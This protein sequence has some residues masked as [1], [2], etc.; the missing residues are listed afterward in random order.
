MLKDLAPSFGT[1]PELG[2]CFFNFSIWQEKLVFLIEEIEKV[3]GTSFAAWDLRIDSRWFDVGTDSVLRKRRNR[4][5]GNKKHVWPLKELDLLESSLKFSWIN[6]RALTREIQWRLLSN[7]WLVFYVRWCSE[8]PWK[9][10]WPWA[11][12]AIVFLQS[13]LELHPNPWLEQMR[14]FE[15]FIF[16][17][18][19]FKPWMLS[20]CFN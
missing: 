3:S 10:Q 9:V 15:T 18:W 5:R 17:W 16:V 1:N 2:G 19:F 11:M 12:R 6:T 20:W 4:W 7:L 13:C 8:L 14:C